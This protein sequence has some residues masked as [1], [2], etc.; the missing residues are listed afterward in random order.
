MKKVDSRTRLFEVMGRLDKTFKPR[1][2]EDF[3]QL[4]GEETP[5]VKTPDF[6][7]E[8][9]PEVEKTEEPANE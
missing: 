2:N 9:T 8:E 7:G 1:L 4:G 3:D 6:G 5:E